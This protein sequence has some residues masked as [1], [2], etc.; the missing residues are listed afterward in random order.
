MTAAA[1]LPYVVRQPRQLGWSADVWV[2][3]G[4]Y[5]R[6]RAGT[7]IKV[8]GGWDAVGSDLL[9]RFASRAKAAAQ[10]W[11]NR[12]GDVRDVSVIVTRYGRTVS[13]RNPAGPS[14]REAWEAE[15]EGGEWIFAR[16]DSPGTP[17]LVFHQPSVDDGS[18]TTPVAIAGSLTRCGALAASGGAAAELARAKT[19]AAAR[20]AR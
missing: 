16:E 6:T 11:A 14:R 15:T 12:P 3:T 17:W 10:V 4:R 13:P 7:V 19:E 5:S 1:P 20:V 9:G 2:V 8:P 18:C